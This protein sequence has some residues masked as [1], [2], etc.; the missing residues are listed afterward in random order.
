MCTMKKETEK[1]AAL[2]NEIKILTKE[3]KELEKEII[4][5]PNPVE[6]MKTEYGTLSLSKR[7]NWNPVDNDKFIEVFGISDF[8]QVATI[9]CSNVKKFFG[10]NRVEELKDRDMLSVKSESKFYTLR[11]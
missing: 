6:K 10:D 11:G 2:K 9:N 5:S 7:V 8:R 3:A 4:S 1:L